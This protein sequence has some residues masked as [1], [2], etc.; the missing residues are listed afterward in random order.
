MGKIEGFFKEG[1]NKGFFTIISK[2]ALFRFFYLAKIKPTKLF[3]YKIMIFI[4]F[5]PKKCVVLR[6]P[7]YRKIQSGL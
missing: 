5:F 6:H 1:D 7:L 4:I 2:R 3:E